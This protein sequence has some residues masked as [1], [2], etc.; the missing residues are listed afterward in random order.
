MTPCIPFAVV[1]IVWITLSESGAVKDIFLPAIQD[2][3][4]TL[5]K[6]FLEDEY[7]KDVAISVY[8]V[9]GAFVLSVC[10][11]V[12]IG[13]CI[14]FF[15]FFSDMMRP[16][17]Y[18]SRYLPIP[19]FV[20]LCILWFGLGDQSKILI[21][22]LG[23]VFQL[24][25]MVADSADKVQRQYF[26][27]AMTLGASRRQLFAKILVPASFPDVVLQCRTAIG[28]AWT[29]LVVAEVAGATQG[30]GFKIVVA[31]RYIQTPKIFAGILVIGLLG[32]LTDLLFKFAHGCVVKPR[33][34]DPFSWFK[35]VALRG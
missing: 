1:A 28:L 15:P 6:L 7:H 23:T 33:I 35:R 17:I 30:L 9:A 18:F 16:F 21:I 24:G 8:R 13:L 20:P 3:I 29:Y 4:V 5:G 22:F 32:I 2:V 34:Y 27:A 31:Q 10:I 26:E 11:A 14:G 12:P 19:A 25:I